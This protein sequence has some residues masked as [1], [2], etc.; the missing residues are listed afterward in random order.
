MILI[1]LR[2]LV[3]MNGDLLNTILYFWARGGSRTQHHGHF[4][5]QLTGAIACMCNYNMSDTLN[6]HWI[7]SQCRLILIFI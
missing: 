5:R 3:T 2:E 6:D 4:W 7:M 1:W